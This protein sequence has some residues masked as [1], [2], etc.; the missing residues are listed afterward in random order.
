[1]DVR[2]PD[3]ETARLRAIAMKMQYGGVGYYASSAF[4]HVDTGSV[5]A[6]PRMSQEQLA[7]LFPDGK[8][9]HLP[10]SGKPLAGYALAKAEIPA[11]N[12]ALAAQASA[13]GGPS[14]G[15]LLANLFGRKDPPPAQT[16]TPTPA[17]TTLAY[18]APEGEETAQ[19]TVP[20]PPRR[21]QELTVVAE[22]GD[23]SMPVPSDTLTV[24][25]LSA[26]S[27]APETESLLG[28]D[29]KAAIRVLFDP[30]ASLLDVG[31]SSE[32]KDELSTTHFTGP[33]VKP[34]PVV[35]QAQASL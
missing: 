31:F 11:R 6:W 20:L 17:A 10:S 5:R 22:A 35:R 16:N 3:V 15:G 33:A 21:P 2:L 25:S 27:I 1:M 8:T 28:L 19:A 4:V 7:R 9:L 14:L 18:A 23:P 24:A 26:Q 12:A 29:Q 13:G 34:L 30:R 32:K